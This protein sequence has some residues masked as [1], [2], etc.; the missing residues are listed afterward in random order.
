MPDIHIEKSLNRMKKINALLSLLQLYVCVCV[1]VRVRVRVRL[2]IR[3]YIYNEK[4]MAT[5][6]HANIFVLTKLISFSFIV[7]S[8]G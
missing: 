4:K 3:I 8:F 7:S 2:R 1:R 6:A 5:L